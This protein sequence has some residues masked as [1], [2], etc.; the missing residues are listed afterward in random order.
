MSRESL[1]IVIIHDSQ[2]KTSFSPTMCSPRWWCGHVEHAYFVSIFFSSSVFIFWRLEGGLFYFLLE[3]PCS[4]VSHTAFFQPQ[5]GISVGSSAERFGF[6]VTCNESVVNFYCQKGRTQIPNSQK[7]ST[8]VHTQN[9][10]V[11]FVFALTS[12]RLL[13][14]W[15]SCS[16]LPS[17]RH[18]LL[19]GYIVMKTKCG[20]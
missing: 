18:V 15:Y 3:P 17:L 2:A 20:R 13:N 1:T 7:L 19:P 8:I 6:I 14:L 11:C 4:F 9:F 12:A 5:R 10:F 16:A